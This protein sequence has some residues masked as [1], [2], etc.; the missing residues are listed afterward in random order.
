M[1][2]MKVIYYY[3]AA[4]ELSTFNIYIYIYIDNNLHYLKYPVIRDIG[5]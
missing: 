3:Y 5:I 2:Y 4:A 1:Y